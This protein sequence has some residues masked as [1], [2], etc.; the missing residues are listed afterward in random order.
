MGW[1]RRG[2]LRC[3]GGP[4]PRNT[5]PA[6]RASASAKASRLSVRRTRGMR[7]CSAACP[8]LCSPA[9]Q[10]R[11][12]SGPRTAHSP[13]HGVP[14]STVGGARGCSLGY[15]RGLSRYSRVLSRYS[16]VLSGGLDGT[17]GGTRRYSPHGA[18]A[19][20]RAVRVHCSAA[21]CCGVHSARHWAAMVAEIAWRCVDYTC[22]QQTTRSRARG[23]AAVDG[24]R[25]GA[26]AARHGALGSTA[27]GT[28]GYCQ[29]PQ[30]YCQGYS[31]VLVR[32][33]EG[34]AKGSAA[35]RVYG[36]RPRSH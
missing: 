15:P 18:A 2:P 34:T 22:A 33:L 27:R 36:A 12:D 9:G 17:L 23:A 29:G 3:A 11:T 6:R 1:S 14:R 21:V 25:S 35:V 20:A 28:R 32:V 26:T 8:S 5:G 24:L 31:R 19:P 16:T 30:G 13:R 10:R 7:R 4:V